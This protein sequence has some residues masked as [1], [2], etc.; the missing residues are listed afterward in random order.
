[1]FDPD[2]AVAARAARGGTG[3]DAVKESLAAARKRLGTT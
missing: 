2:H 3:P 1:V